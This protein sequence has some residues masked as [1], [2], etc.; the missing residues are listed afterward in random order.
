MKGTPPILQSQGV[1][2]TFEP[3]QYDKEQSFTTVPSYELFIQGSDQALIKAAEM[4]HFRPA[5]FYWLISLL[6]LL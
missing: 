4:D 6:H 2:A 3:M 1:Q 5:A